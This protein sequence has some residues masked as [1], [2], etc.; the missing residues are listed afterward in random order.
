[1]GDLVYLA[2]G[3]AALVAWSAWCYYLGRAD[4]AAKLRRRPR[5]LWRSE[6]WPR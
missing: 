1:M 5:V 2:L 4:L 3:S 6:E